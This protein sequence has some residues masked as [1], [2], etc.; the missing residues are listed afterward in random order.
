[1]PIDTAKQGQ[2]TPAC[3][4][5]PRPPLFCARS[6]SAPSED[7]QGTRSESE[8]DR[9]RNQWQTV[10]RATPTLQLNAYRL[11]VG[12]EV[13]GLNRVHRVRPIPRSV[14]SVSAPPSA[15][16]AVC[17]QPTRRKATAPQEQEGPSRSQLSRIESSGLPPVRQTAGTWVRVLVLASTSAE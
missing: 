4:P 2:R 14:S 17:L 9:V 5:Y 3:T 15:G 10:A 8:T 6:H 16:C 1:M 11:G 7:H 13:D 12:L